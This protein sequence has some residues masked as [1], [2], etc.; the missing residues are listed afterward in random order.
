MEDLRARFKSCFADRPINFQVAANYFW[1]YHN[2]SYEIDAVGKVLR[3]IKDQPT[4]FSRIFRSRLPDGPCPRFPRMHRDCAAMIWK[5]KFPTRK[6]PKCTRCGRN[7]FEV[8]ETGIFLYEHMQQEAVNSLET[9]IACANIFCTDC[10]ES[11]FRCDRCNKALPN[12]HNHAFAE[13]HSFLT[14][15]KV[16]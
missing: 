12:L 5:I 11:T 3:K 15:L 16:V 2:L 7:K 13:H 6:A 8:E 4:G 1:V 14:L 10:V 9:N